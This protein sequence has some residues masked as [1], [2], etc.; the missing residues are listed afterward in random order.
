MRK[1][2]RIVILIASCGGGAAWMAGQG[3][4]RPVYQTNVDMVVLTFGVSGA[5]GNAIRGLKPEDVRIT[6]NGI[7]QKI[8]SFSEGNQP[9]MQL[10]AGAPAGTN[11]F[12][13]FDTS[14]HMYQTYPYVCD[15][16]AD[17]IRRL[18]ADDSIAL[19]TFSRNLFRAAG[20]TKDHLIARAGLTNVVAGDDTALF[21]ALLLT[22]RD[23]ARIP[24]RKAVVMFSNGADNA[25]MVGPD[26]VATVAQDEGIP[27]YVITTRPEKPD[28]SA[29][30]TDAALERIV[31]RSGGK[32]YRALNWQ[33]QA[34][35]FDAIRED[36]GSTYTASYYPTANDEESFRSIRVEI[37]CPGGKQYRVRA[38]AGYDP[39][40][41][42]SGNSKN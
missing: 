34:R 31:A 10:E 13:L 1:R 9:V 40:K 30:P 33:N 19:Y 42:H 6:E 26:D 18:D 20:L 16:L 39:P 3:E 41:R 24:G 23:A 17:F 32:L 27:V 14:N 28:K 15:A 4:Q 22:L 37:V 21:N 11:V 8:V 35:A 12:V 25:S 5:K 29:E 36:L 7:S 38:R 2:M